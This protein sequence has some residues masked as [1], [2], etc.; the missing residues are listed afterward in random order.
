MEKPIIHAYFICYNEEVI[1]PHL[2]SHY[3][4]FCEEITILDNGSNDRSVEIINSFKNTKIIPYDSNGELN[5]AIYILIKNQIWKK[6]IGIADY[7]IVGDTDEFIYH[8]NI[9][10]FLT[11]SKNEG[12]TLF[13]PH[14]H[15]MVSDIDFNLEKDDNIFEKVN[16]G[17]RTEVLDKMMMFDCNK[18]KEINYSFGCHLANPVGEVKIYN[19]SDLK[20]L[21]YK[22]LGIKLHNEKYKIRAERLSK[23]NLQNG[24][25]SYYLMSKDEQIKDYT[26]Y[27]NQ[28]KKVI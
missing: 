9:L 26:G 15:H 12:Y 20:M 6:S 3:S 10:D 17:V 19:N 27:V 16:E 24:L 23:F 5:D 22:F 18:I 21:H 25:G 14:G 8:E 7:V 28:R 4:K 2:L 11:K 13:K 1:L